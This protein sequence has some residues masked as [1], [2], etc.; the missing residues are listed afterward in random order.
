[1]G[2]WGNVGKVIAF[3]VTGPAKLA[4]KA[5]DKVAEK[6]AMKILQTVVRQLMTVLGGAG[7]VAADDDVT[8]V[9]SALAVLLSVAWSLWNARREAKKGD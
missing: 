9:A 2:F 3:P 6:T 7:Y 1:M 4:K 5:T 8:A